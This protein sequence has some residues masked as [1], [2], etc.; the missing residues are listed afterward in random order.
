MK[1]RITPHCKECI[2]EIQGT[3]YKAEWWHLSRKYI[4]KALDWEKHPTMHNESRGELEV[5]EA[6][7]LGKI[8][9]VKTL[10]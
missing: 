4:F 6:I 10:I 3:R 1:S 9:I 2:I 7:K 5:S 8:K